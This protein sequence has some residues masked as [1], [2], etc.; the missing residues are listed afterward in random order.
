MAPF[1]RRKKE[2]LTILEEIYTSSDLK[3]PKPKEL[4]KEYFS[5]PKKVEKLLSISIVVCGVIAI[6]AGFFQ[7]RN[8]LVKYFVPNQKQLAA[9]TNIV[10]AEDLLGL[11]KKD[12]DADTL[13][14]YDEL[15]VYSTSPYLKDSDSDGTDDAKEITLGTSPNCPKGQNCFTTDSASQGDSL[16]LTQQSQQVRQLLIQSGMTKE[17]LDQFTDEEI[18]NTYQQVMAENGTA[19]ATGSLGQTGLSTGQVNQMSSQEIRELLAKAGMSEEM[20]NQISDQD[21]MQL[22]SETL[23]GSQTATVNTNVNSTKSGSTQSSTNK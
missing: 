20:L 5:D 9:K 11:Q 12:T 14:D 7:V 2:N 22:V 6:G 21:L 17:E 3:K 10:P 4:L 16:L 23:S 19:G 15:Y 8:N 18:L 13:S 1:G